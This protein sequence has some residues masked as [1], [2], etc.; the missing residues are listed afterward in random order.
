MN[1]SVRVVA[2]CL[3]C[4]CI[5]LVPLAITPVLPL[6][7]FYNHIARYYVLSHMAGNPVLS[8]NYDPAWA[9]LPNLGLDVIAT[10]LLMVVP[11]L[12][13][14]KLVI[15]FILLIQYSGVLFLYRALH[16]RINVLPVVLLPGIL[17]SYILGWGFSNFLLGLGL[18]FWNLGLWFRLREQRLPLAIMAC[19]LGA[20]VI[21]FCHGFAFAIYGVLLGGMELG[22]WLHSENRRLAVVP[23]TVAALA[24]QAVIPAILFLNMR[25]SGATGDSGSI[26]G[27]I[28]KHNGS[29]SLFARLDYEFWYRLRTIVRV[30]ESSYPFFDYASFALT[31]AV[32][33]VAL[34]KGW[35]RL[36][37]WC[38]LAL[39]FAAL[40][41]VLT[42]PSL[43]GVGYVSDRMPLVFVL[44]F[45]AALGFANPLPKAGPLSQASLLPQG[46]RIAVALL[47]GVM[48]VRIAAMAIGWSDYARHYADFREV[49]S[50]IP[51]GALVTD[52]L[53]VGPDRRD[54]LLP[55]CQMYRPLLVV[56]N[57]D[58]A[59]LFANPS[60]Q[61]IRLAGPL[62][63]AQMGGTGKPDLRVHSTP[64]IYD[65]MLA[66]IAAKG[67][68]EYILMCGRE[69]LVRSLP[70]GLTI[71]AE[72]GG[73]T[74]LRVD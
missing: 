47:A 48:L 72:K 60:Q 25:T 9:L 50:V 6:I 69:R 13:A 29:G 26:I 20:V 63:A 31:V 28:Q 57:G 15:G 66:D 34:W 8:A 10:P 64:G 43:F 1:P 36:H 67:R 3:F 5:L 58:V 52:V 71:A 45:V 74:V 54:G 17:Y 65:D 27:A 33:A 41:C 37:R 51:K 68:Y 44:L 46:G 38:L 4:A 12:L 56:L 14:A 11:P 2:V 70:A 59:A 19:S 23:R 21:F 39:V 62:L 18:V 53:P 73:I 22:R 35:F 40:L 32:I 24:V 61:P 30:A 7:D 16:G 55:R 49:T 42:P